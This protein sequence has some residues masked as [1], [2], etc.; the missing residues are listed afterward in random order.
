MA[1]PALGIRMLQ[2][3]AHATD[4]AQTG[5]GLLGR[6]A[7]GRLVLGRLALGSL[8]LALAGC[9]GGGGGGAASTPG[10]TAEGAV[11]GADYHPLN[12]G[13]RWR[14]V[15]SAQAPT[16]VAVTGSESTPSGPAMLMHSEIPPA[17]L[18]QR[19]VKTAS[20][21]VLVPG[22]DEDPVL[23]ALGPLQLLRLPLVAGDDW[24]LAERALD[25]RF[26]VDLDG[27]P[28]A[29]T[30]RMQATV[31]GFETVATPA[32]TFSR[33]AHVRTVLTRT[34]QLSSTRRSVTTT[35]TSD[36]WYAPDVGLVRNRLVDSSDPPGTNHEMSLTHY[37]V[38][39]RSNDVTA[40]TVAS[41]TPL[42]EGQAYGGFPDVR[43]V[44]SE[45][46]DTRS[47]G[48]AQITLT[49]ESGQVMSGTTVWL[50]DRTLAL[51]QSLILPSGRY[52]ARLTGRATDPA[53]NALADAPSWRFTLDA[54]GPA[55]TLVQP[56]AG[57]TEVALDTRVVIT[58]DEVPDPLTVTPSTVRLIDQRASSDV[59]ATLSLSDRT[60]TLTP[61]APLR[62]GGRYRVSVSGIADRHGNTTY[63]SSWTFGTDPGRFATPQPLFT[64]AGITAAAIGDV[65]GDGRA[66]AL[67]A[68]G[69]GWGAADEF[70]LQLRRSLGGGN[71][72]PA[73]TLASIAAYGAEIG[74][75]Q[76]ADLDRN[77]RLAVVA[78][79]SGRGLQI[80][81]R[82][83]DG[84]LASSQVI[85]TPHSAV[86]RVMDMD[87]DG[88]PDLVSA[89][90]SGDAVSVWLQQADGRFGTA[91][92]VPVTVGSFGDI[93]VGDLDG[94]GQPD[95]AVVNGNAPDA[96]V[97]IV[98]RTAGGGYAA[99]RV[100]ALPNAFAVAGVAIGD[101]NGDGRADL[102]LAQSGGSL[103]TVLAQQ[104]DGTLRASAQVSGIGNTQRVRVVDLDG[105]GQG[106]L[107][108]LSWSWGGYPIALNRQRR[109]GT[110]GAVE[111]W[112]VDDY[113]NWRPDLAA[114]GDLDGDGRPDLL[115][116][117][118][119]LR[120]RT[121]AWTEATATPQAAPRRAAA[122][123]A[124]AASARPD[125]KAPAAHAGSPLWRAL[126][127]PVPA[128]GSAAGH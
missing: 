22:A 44:F 83:A 76:M 38:A 70:T 48:M 73:Q 12:L 23:Q 52:T 11:A 81:R 113:G 47:G 35:L 91:T 39:G 5:A 54:S 69:F 82:Q 72:A 119:W 15:D 107:D 60:V 14:Y 105:D 62:M 84:T 42:A 64:S 120:Q 106:R 32:G 127:R 8:V 87:G 45:A 121:V 16:W 59:P 90:F 6:L 13:D 101:V 51:M 20:G 26:D 110:L 100:P 30:V 124:A 57:A 56:L 53:G 125:A 99:P 86:V 43:M 3:M 36:D 74:S 31:L 66:D 122:A 50:D 28:D 109:D 85:D 49:H 126:I 40:P 67:V 92:V 97:A 61:S 95:I 27:I 41:V 102:V 114:V 80:F 79:A 123:T 104:A 29:M 77:G 88:R 55:A 128:T 116:A 89:P 96:P 37:R 21:V 103:V 58:L 46:M 71:F 65:D 117:G 18:T 108:V 112:P 10:S 17:R 118:Q 25:G 78:A 9:G 115:Y 2:G 19:I 93:D 7:M 63:D 98:T 94:D 111:T 24:V 75:L 1:W 68:V 33:C 34:A 4:G